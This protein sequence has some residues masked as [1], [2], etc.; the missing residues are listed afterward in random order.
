[1]N[2][3]TFEMLYSRFQFTQ[4]FEKE[5]VLFYLKFFFLVQ[6]IKGRNHCVSVVYCHL[7]AIQKL[8]QSYT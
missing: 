7:F 2:R 1:M 3:F 4:K 6:N 5:K 8:W